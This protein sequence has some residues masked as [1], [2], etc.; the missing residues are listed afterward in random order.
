[1]SPMLMT[2]AEQKKT[3]ANRTLKRTY[4][5][6]KFDFVLQVAREFRFTRMPCDRV[7]DELFSGSL[8][9]AKNGNLKLKDTT[10]TITNSK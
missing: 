6:G 3:S 1:M 9:E 10:D 2:A 7:F 5:I 4:L 8:E